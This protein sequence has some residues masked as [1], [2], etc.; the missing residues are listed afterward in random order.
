M[1]DIRQS[2]QLYKTKP[3]PKWNIDVG[4]LLKRKLSHN[5][6][7]INLI[8]IRLKHFLNSWTFEWIKFYSNLSKKKWQ[9]ETQV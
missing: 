6:N 7:S 8:T 2:Y 1:S 5:S 9:F 3:Q 4:L